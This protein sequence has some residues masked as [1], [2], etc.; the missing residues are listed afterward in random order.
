MKTAEQWVTEQWGRFS[1]DLYRDADINE[2]LERYRG[3][4]DH[5]AKEGVVI[6]QRALAAV[7][8]RMKE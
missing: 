4:A 6:A 1:E 3:F 5:L 7:V 2:L 8:K